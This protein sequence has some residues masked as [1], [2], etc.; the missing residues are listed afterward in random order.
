[1]TTI[2]GYLRL[3]PLLVA[4]LMLTVAGCSRNSGSQNANSGNVSDGAA[5]SGS[6][7]AQSTGPR[8]SDY[9]P[10]RDGRICKYSNYAHIM[11][12]A[13]NTTQTLKY[14][15]VHKGSD[16][17]HF[18]VK[19][20]TKATVTNS[21]YGGTNR[22]PSL[23]EAQTLKYVLANDG[24]LRADPQLVNKEFWDAS[25]DKFVVY[26]PVE[27]LRQGKSTTSS[28]EV[29]GRP[30][31]PAAQ[32]ELK[33]ELKPGESALKM[34]AAYAVEGVPPKEITTPAG[35]FT[36][37][38]GISLKLKDAKALNASAKTDRNIEQLMKLLTK[39]TGTTTVWFARGVGIVQSGTKG[40]LAAAMASGGNTTSNGD[41]AAQVMKLEG[42]TNDASSEPI[43][44]AS[45]PTPPKP[46]TK[47][48]TTTL[49]GSQNPRTTSS[50]DNSG[51]SNTGGYTGSS[52]NGEKA[53]LDQAVGD[54]YRAAGAEEWAYTYD[55][56]ASKTQSMFTRDEWSRRNQW[57]WDSNPTIYHIDSINLDNASQ[58]STAEVKL[59]ITGK[60]GSS[61]V[62]T[63]YF[64]QENGEWK[65]RFSAEETSLFMP[66][67]TFKEFVDAQTQG[68]T[69]KPAAGQQPQQP[70]QQ[71]SVFERLVGEW[72]RHGEAMTIK[73]DRT[74]TG[75]SRIYS[76]PSGGICMPD[77]AKCN[78]K[79]DL[80]FTTLA[81]GVQVEVTSIKDGEYS[82]LQVGDTWELTLVDD[83]LMRS[84]GSFDGYWCNSRT[85]TKNALECGA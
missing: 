18:T 2:R 67:A 20:N 3:A 40:G 45:E 60:D 17:T 55:H 35:T 63:T 39:L 84:S 73:P 11:G 5:A 65:H 59:R 82:N 31:L 36:D 44:A 29:T 27:V 30:L 80:R 77:S 79:Y 48:E 26:P 7:Q 19:N 28:S 52:N 22:Q 74:G 51:G 71:N 6:N 16:G 53:S 46:T 13:V 43:T 68:D 58:G 23:T 34:R 9:L 70:S 21:E 75:V 50:G 62:R 37:V 42:C 56:L 57:F 61:W 54:Y 8:W 72:Y 38:V 78:V 47:P 83:N 1:M 25:V 76:T 15:N 66:D 41:G 32:A 4:A 24:T 81:N 14:T 10:V 12:S 49:S 64:V 33:K 69:S 85:S